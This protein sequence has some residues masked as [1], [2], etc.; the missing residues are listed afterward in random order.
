[1]GGGVIGGGWAARFMLNGVDVRL[2]GPSAGALERV[3]KILLK[4][5]RAY[6]RLTQVPL[7]PEGSLTV[8]ESVADAVRDVELVQESAPERL[9]LKQPLL[10]AASR[11]AAPDTLICSSSSGLAPSL[12]QAQ[13]NHPE[14]LLVAHPFNPA[15]LMPL[16]ELCAGQHTRPETL[17]RAAAIYRSVGMHPLV[18]R[19]EVDGFI[20]NRLQEAMWRE[21]LWL[22]HDGV[23]T[24]QEVDDAVR[25]SFGL[26]RA[27]LGPF[28]IGG[29]AVGMR[30]YMEQWGPMLKC[31]WTK[32]TDVP[33]L[34]DAFLD[35][36]A[37]QS[38]LQASVENLTFPELEE[39]RD[40]CLVSVLQ[41]LRTQRYG[42]GETLARWEQVL[43][44]RTAPAQ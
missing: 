36:L 21:A 43:R 20:A 39:K 12:L 9:D 2:Y 23:A 16:V 18:V 29:G 24:V 27:I 32:L 19:K 28:R 34:T 7:P 3:E 5:R 37:E 4:A 30:R 41:A 42:A 6:R 22:V 8:V 35:R 33:E 25:Y 26:R 1:M 10:A 11:A 15:Y 40:D 38:E 14:R 44:K 31:P 17:A 13:M